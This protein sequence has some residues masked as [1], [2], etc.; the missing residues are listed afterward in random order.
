MANQHLEKERRE[1]QPERNERVGGPRGKDPATHWKTHVLQR[2]AT[3][4]WENHGDHDLPLLGAPSA[5]HTR[6]LIDF[7]GVANRDME[8]FAF[9]TRPQSIVKFIGVAVPKGSVPSAYLICF[10]HSAQQKDYPNGAGLLTKGVGDYLTGRMQFSQQISTSGKDIAV[11]VPVAIGG[12]GEFESDQK[13]IS[14]CLQEIETELFN[15]SRPLPPLLL[16]SNSDGLLKMARFI[17]NC[18]QL[19]VQVKAIYDFDGSRVIAAA[20]ITLAG[21][22]ARVFRYDGSN[23]LQP[24]K[25]ES[26]LAFLSRTLMANPARIPL[27]YDRWEK[28]FRFLPNIKQK[29]ADS[30]TPVNEKSMWRERMHDWLHHFIPTCMLTHGLVNTPGL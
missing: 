7:G 19:V 24:A 15:V 30:K 13:F 8:T 2:I 20:G 22:K 27:P 17:Q 18:P 12:S 28:H 29:L 4:T 1:Y 10:R 23:A 14:Q 3:P 16:A 21:G 25:G 9:E 6:W 26:E 5:L 11:V